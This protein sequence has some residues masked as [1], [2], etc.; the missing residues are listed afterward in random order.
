MKQYWVI[1]DHLD[2]G[3]YLMPEDTPE[4]ELE[5]VENTCDTCGDSDSIIGQFS[6]WKQLKKEMTNDEGWCSYS[7]EYLQ[8]VFEE[9]NQ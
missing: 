5:E 3:F 1:E 6:N 7:D 9:D 8:S 4:E 2:G